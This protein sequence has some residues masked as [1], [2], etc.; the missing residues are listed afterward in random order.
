M[1]KRFLPLLFLLPA[2]IA[3]LACMPLRPY[4]KLTDATSQGWTAGMAGGGSGTEYSFKVQI[5]TRES[6]RFDSV[7]MNNKA[8][9]IQAV[10]GKVYDPKSILQKNDTID[11]R[12]SDVIPGKSHDMDGNNPPSASPAKHAP[13][14][15]TG[16][17]LIR[18]YVNNKAH[19]FTVS[20][21]RKL[22]PVNMP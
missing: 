22:E 16:A 13:V 7:W 17:A 20:Q 1:K 10:K 4:F 14:S 12:I 18:F 8:F 2:V 5:H 11:L 19:Y 21:I 15:Y 9:K 3:L 6:I